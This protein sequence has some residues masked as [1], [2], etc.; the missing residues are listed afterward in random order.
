MLIHER[1]LQNSPGLQKSRVAPPAARRGE[2]KNN[3]KSELLGYRVGV[4]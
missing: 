4:S 1:L 2:S 3:F